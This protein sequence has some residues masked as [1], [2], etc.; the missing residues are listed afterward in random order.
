[1]LGSDEGQSNASRTLNVV[2]ENLAMA[3]SSALSET[4]GKSQR[5]GKGS[6]LRGRDNT[7]P[8]FPR[9]DIDR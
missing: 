1:M 2:T 8:P 9:P 7:F 5:V 6:G 3:F 4:L